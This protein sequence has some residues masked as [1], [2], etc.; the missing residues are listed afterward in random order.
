MPFYTEGVGQF[1]PRVE[2][3]QPSGSRTNDAVLGTLKGFLVRL[4]AK[5]FQG[6]AFF[7]TRLNGPRVAIAQPWAQIRQHLRCRIS[8]N[9]QARLGI[10]EMKLVP[11]KAQPHRRLLLSSKSRSCTRYKLT[12]AQHQEHKSFIAQKFSHINSGKQ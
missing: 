9:S 6:S 7:Q 11:G 3:W 12:F 5:H 2:L 4:R 1:Q 10:E 8:F